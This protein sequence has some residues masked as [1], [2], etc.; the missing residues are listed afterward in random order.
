MNL[1]KSTTQVVIIQNRISPDTIVIV[2]LTEPTQKRFRVTLSRES[3]TDRQEV[4]EEWYLKKGQHCQLEF[5]DDEVIEDIDD[6]LRL[7][8]DH[9]A[10][11]EGRLT[12]NT[13]A[14]L[15]FQN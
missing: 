8:L 3:L 13:I 14:I 2:S 7:S 15:G 4:I 9:S 12:C 5:E 6:R 10:A 1:D 11:E